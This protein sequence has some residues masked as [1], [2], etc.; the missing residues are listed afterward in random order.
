MI[1]GQHQQ[2]QSYDQRNGHH[3]VIVEHQDQGFS[4][5]DQNIVYE[6][7]YQET[8]EV[9]GGG[10]SE[11]DHV[12]S[13]Y[14]GGKFKLWLKDNLPSFRGNLQYANSNLSMALLGKNQNFFTESS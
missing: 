2:Q 13:Y 4:E 5:V 12:V 1:A 11:T 8:G 3:E 14:N 9:N 7:H 6:E 10:L